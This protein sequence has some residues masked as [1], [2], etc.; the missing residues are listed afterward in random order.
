MSGLFGLGQRQS[1]PSAVLA[2]TP[3]AATGSPTSRTLAD[4]FADVGNAKN[5]GAVGDD[6]A[7]EYAFLQAS[8]DALE[9]GDVWIVPPGDY[10]V[11]QTIIMRA[12]R[13]CIAFFGTLKP[14]GSFSGYL[15]RQQYVSA[16]P[17][18]INVGHSLTVFRFTINGEWQ[19]R[20]ALF[21]NLYL[22]SMGHISISK[23]YGTAI[24]VEIGYETSWFQPSI[25]LC[26]HRVREW[27]AAAGDWSSVTAYT[28][29]TY[30]RRA[31]AVYNAGTAYAATDHVMYNGEAYKSV[32][33]ANTGNTPG[34]NNAWWVKI[35]TEYFYATE[36]TTNEDPFLTGNTQNEGGPWRNVLPYDPLLDLSCDTVGGLVD[37]QYFYGL[38]IRDSDSRNLLYIDNNAN[39][40]PVANIEFYGA[41]IH[42]ITAGIGAASGGELTEGNDDN[43]HVLLG[44]SWQVKFYGGNIRLGGQSGQGIGLMLGAVNPAKTINEL[45]LHGDFSGEAA[46]QVGI[47]VGSSVVEV[48][49]FIGQVNDQMTGT[50]GRLAADPAQRLSDYHPMSLRT[51]AGSL[52]R[53]GKSWVDEI[54]SG[55]FRLASGV[56]AESVAGAEAFRWWRSGGKTMYRL[57]LAV[58]ADNAAAVS[59]G[60]T[61]DMYYR[62]AT[63]E[64]RVVV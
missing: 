56:F 29:G 5:F 19:S 38:D 16:D 62:T 18:L 8:L 33:V 24:K 59:G 20:G 44:R 27:V 34:T 36:A 1:L 7:D 31:H 45:V 37:H 32:A 63:G 40:R 14:H 9:D 58:Y 55:S 54:T 48:K 42:C 3:V 2:N 11:S 4:R 13:I 41:Q 25:T 12:R 64:V 52:S 46:D 47:V 22:S 49:Q 39:S 53:P 57:P 61:A 51:G 23:T 43:V 35:P 21:D 15:F 50:R 6:V 60:L 28:T 26:K 17:T 30:V 10:R